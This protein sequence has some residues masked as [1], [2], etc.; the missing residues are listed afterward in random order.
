MH[1]IKL[2]F[3]ATLDA[4]L[5]SLASHYNTQQVSAL[6]MVDLVLNYWVMLPDR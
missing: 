4:V 2:I 1:K 6:I 5:F 3:V